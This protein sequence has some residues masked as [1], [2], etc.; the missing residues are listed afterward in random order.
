MSLAVV[1]FLSDFNVNSRSIH[2]LLFH[3][4]QLATVAE[5]S[6]VHVIPWVSVSNSNR[7]TV[8][9]ASIVYVIVLYVNVLHVIVLYVNVLHV[10]V[11]Y[12]IE[13]H[14]IVCDVNVLYCM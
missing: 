2:L 4:F 7:A 10:I 11:L 5:A 8:V 6:I 9:E 13:L 3:G 12:V 14:V 1:H